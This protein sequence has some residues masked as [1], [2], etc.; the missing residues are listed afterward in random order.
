MSS[1]NEGEL[2]DGRYRVGPLMGRGG[3][4]VVHR[5]HDGHL[6][7]T[8]ALKIYPAG[9]LEVAG[10]QQ[11]E[12]RSLAA[13]TDPGIVTLFDARLDRELAYLVMEYVDGED[14][15]HRLRRGPLSPNR[16]AALL[17]S[18]AGGL[19]AAH[20][21]GFVHRDVKP[22]NILIPHEPGES[23]ARLADFG[24]ARLVD[25]ARLT[26]TGSVL[27]TA[28]YLAP[29]QIRGDTASPAADVYALGLLLTECLTGEHPFAGTA[30]EA[31]VARLHRAPTI[32]A[33]VESPWRDL[34][35]HMTASDP[36]ARPTSREVATT[37][38]GLAA[39][40]AADDD[41]LAATAA[42][43]PADMPT[44]AHRAATAALDP[45]DV[46]TAVLPA[47]TD[48]LTRPATWAVRPTAAD[49]DDPR[50]R[51]VPVIVAGIV[52]AL[53]VVA[54]V[55]AIATL[56]PG[57]GPT[58]ASPSPATPAATPGTPSPT[59][60]TVASVESQLPAQVR[61]GLAALDT[62]IQGQGLDDLR[63]QLVSAIRA[64]DTAAEAALLDALDAAAANA[65][66]DTS[67]A[68]QAATDQLR[69]ALGLEQKPAEHRESGKPPAGPG[70][71]KDP[72]PGR[73]RKDP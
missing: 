20:E 12:A 51:R 3:M 47:N 30:I 67:A 31:A 16:T 11:A 24:I 1:V 56:G 45:G 44:V 36:D 17:A 72:G 71:S 63:D 25:S 37:A 18:V 50:R 54:V 49:A 39:A 13:L 35:T 60:S 19:A 22:G 9:A 23:R 28:A 5:A 58:A 48:A 33:T 27:G 4:G 29:E 65:S 15:A 21:R 46:P 7:R 26:T 42:L 57:R 40:S 64:G 38:A 69:S 55:T 2:L 14:L 6:G 61:S 43:S 32:P 68:I 66:A 8:V 53:L 41:L 62:A 52:S 59:A 70:K 73:G 34:L 10:R